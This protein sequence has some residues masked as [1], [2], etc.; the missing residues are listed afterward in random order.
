MSNFVDFFDFFRE[1]LP[2][3]D[4]YG[5]GTIMDSNAVTSRIFRTQTVDRRFVTINFVNYFITFHVT[6]SDETLYFDPIDR[7]QLSNTAYIIMRYLKHKEI[8]K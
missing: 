6:D 8:P 2:L 1:W 7:V 4:K 3:C 5:I